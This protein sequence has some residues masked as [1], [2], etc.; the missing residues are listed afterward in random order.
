MLE[1]EMENTNISVESNKPKSLTAQESLSV[2]DIVFTNYKNEISESKAT[3]A[4][5]D[6]FFRC[7]KKELLPESNNACESDELSLPLNLVS[8]ESSAKMT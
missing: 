3:S 5:K 6:A 2:S 8:S 1:L 7:K 4:L